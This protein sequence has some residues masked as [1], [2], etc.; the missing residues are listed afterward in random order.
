MFS[1]WLRYLIYI[2]SLPHIPLSSPLSSSL[3]SP[4]PP[5]SPSPPRSLSRAEALCDAIQGEEPNFGAGVTVSNLKD[6]KGSG[7]LLLKMLNK[8]EGLRIK[9]PQ[10]KVRREGSRGEGRR[11]MRGE[12]WKVARERGREGEG[13]RERERDGRERGRREGKARQGGGSRVSWCYSCG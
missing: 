2:L 9:V 13:E 10:M 6:G 11:G 8:T 1:Y 5:S 12:G 4:S 7:D 3:P